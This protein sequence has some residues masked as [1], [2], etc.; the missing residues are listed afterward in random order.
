VSVSDLPAVN[1]SL[2]A[3]ATI[4]IASGY[5]AIRRQRVTVHRT[6]MISAVAASAVFLACYLTYHIDRTYVSGLGPTRFAGEGVARPI[7]FAILTSHTIL[8]AATVPLVL[9][10]V[11][12]AWRNQIERHRRLA[13]WTLPIWLYVSVTGVVIYLMLYH[14][15]APG[16]SS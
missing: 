3:L 9:I 16:V 6:L 4:L 13:R 5:V 2:N 11:Y 10:T 14:W 12:R 15:F 8:A 7:Y 1:A